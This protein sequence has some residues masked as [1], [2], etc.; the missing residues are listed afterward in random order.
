MSG[1]RP[2][3][4]WPD[5]R[6]ARAL[7]EELEKTYPTDTLLKVCCLPTID[8]AIELS[9]GNPSKALL[10]L[11]PVAPYELAGG[12]TLYP[13]Y[14][15]GQA[16]LETHNGV[17]AAAEFRKLLE[18]TGIV[19]NSVTGSL[20]RLQTG[21]A[22]APAGDTAKARAGYQEFFALWKDADP[23]IPIY[24]QAKAEYAK[25]R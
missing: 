12:L 23:G 16:Y 4:R 19:V 17:A 24:K 5:I 8:A 15:R 3:S 21:R 14:L 1:S 7:V 11:Q 25:L 6:Q 13:A 10:L 18:H 22:Y 2:P 9:S 20:A